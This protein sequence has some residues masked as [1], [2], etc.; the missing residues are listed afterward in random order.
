M[1]MK[2]HVSDKIRTSIRGVAKMKRIPLAEVCRDAGI[3]YDT[4]RKY[5]NGSADMTV[6][7]VERIADAL[8]FTFVGLVNW[9]GK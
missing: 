5:L 2:Q 8:D 3:H 4:L 9:K 1:N 7:K 6:T